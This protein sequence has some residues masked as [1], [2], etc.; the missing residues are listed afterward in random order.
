MAHIYADLVADSSSTV[1]T[2]S[3]ALDAPDFTGYRNI[4]DVREVRRALG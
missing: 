3:F 1:G 4:E 2:G